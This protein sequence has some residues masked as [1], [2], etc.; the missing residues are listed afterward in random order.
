M[1]AHATSS[2]VAE[3][4]L[5]LLAHVA[6]GGL[7]PC[8]GSRRA[9]GPDEFEPSV[10]VELQFDVRLTGEVRSTTTPLASIRPA[11]RHHIDHTTSMT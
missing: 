3:E 8:C 10:S 1:D 9:V 11:H 2:A 6:L 5:G 4:A 7:C